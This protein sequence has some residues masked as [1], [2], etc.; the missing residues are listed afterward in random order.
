MEKIF[1]KMTCLLECS[2]KYLLGA[3]APIK[4]VN[5]LVISRLNKIFGHFCGTCATHLGYLLRGRHCNLY[6]I[7]VHLAH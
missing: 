5:P 6:C 3:V 7:A 2:E 4:A 1:P